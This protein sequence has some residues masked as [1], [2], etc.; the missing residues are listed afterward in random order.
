LSEKQHEKS[1]LVVKLLFDAYK[2]NT[3][4]QF[5]K[6]IKSSSFDLESDSEIEDEQAVMNVKK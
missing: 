2:F 6:F 5:N 3:S 4:L 1:S